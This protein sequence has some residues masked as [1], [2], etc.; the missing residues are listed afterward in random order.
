MCPP[1]STGVGCILDV[2]DVDKL[3]RPPLALWDA[4]EVFGGDAVVVVMEYNAAVLA[5]FEEEVLSDS[6]EPGPG[7]GLYPDVLRLASLIGS[8]VGEGDVDDVADSG[9]TVV[10]Q[11]GSLGDC[12]CFI[13]GDGPGPGK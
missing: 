13:V 5:V 12:F 11:S 3:Q 7:S 4:F 8:R 1:F 10:N 9:L 6:V 2:F